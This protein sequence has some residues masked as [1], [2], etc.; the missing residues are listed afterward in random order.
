MSPSS[1]DRNSPPHTDIRQWLDPCIRDQES[2]PRFFCSLGSSTSDYRWL[3][4]KNQS[5]YWILWQ[6]L[7]FIHRYHAVAQIEQWKEIPGIFHPQL[8]QEITY[9]GTGAIMEFSGEKA[10]IFGIVTVHIEL[11][12]YPAKWKDLHI[13]N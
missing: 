13:H 10:K 6:N 8:L 3:I 5:P 1:P 7:N 12:K 4:S 2:H 9:A 11:I